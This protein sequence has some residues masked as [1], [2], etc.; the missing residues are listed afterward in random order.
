MSF[1]RRRFKRPW[2][3]RVGRPGTWFAPAANDESTSVTAVDTCF[4]E[5]VSKMPDPPAVLVIPILWNIQ[6]SVSDDDLDALVAAGGD[7]GHTLTDNLNALRHK[8]TLEG[9]TL[10]QIRGQVTIQGV[11][12]SGG[13]SDITL[14]HAGIRVADVLDDGILD[15]EPGFN[16]NCLDPWMWMDTWPI[17]TAPNSFEKWGV[18]STRTFHLNVKTKRRM[19]A[20]QVCNLYLQLDAPASDNTVSYFV[21]PKLRAFVRKSV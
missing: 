15:Y 6:Q 5:F 17:T 7:T 2:N 3:R 19:K 9:W 21:S 16:E 12:S 13:N 11:R 1:K 18:P 4:T 8:P 10:R 14:I 20:E